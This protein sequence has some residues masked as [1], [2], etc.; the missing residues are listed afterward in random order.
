MAL[1]ASSLSQICKSIGQFV[2]TELNQDDTVVRVTIGNPGD[3]APADVETNRL[4]IFFFRFEPF[5]FDADL[6]PGETMF[7]RTHC[8]MTPFSISEQSVSTGENDLRLIGE[9]LR[10]F[11]ERPVLLINAGGGDFQVQVVM[12]SLALDQLNQLWSTQGEVT[13]RPSVLYEIS[14]APVIPK[15]QAVGAPIVGSLGLGVSGTMDR[16]TEPA[17][18][19]A[20][21]PD[22]PVTLV[23][24][25]REDWAPAICFVRGGACVQSLGFEA[26]GADIGAFAPRV[27]VAGEPG[28]AVSL[29]W[30]VWDASSGWSSLASTTPGTALGPRLDSDQVPAEA[31]TTAV[32]LPFT[33]HAGQAVLYAERSYVRA[34]DG[35]ALTVRSNP[36][37]VN[38]FGG[39]P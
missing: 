32:A 1:V 21:G 34:L 11:H 39:A 2:S 25:S 9:V 13:Y 10:V 28:A 14:L 23:D 22:V 29:R 27:W 26:G 18:S 31:D 12:Q 17:A 33:D 24:T 7:L 16:S 37:L 38:V 36:I 15:V 19:S 8:L 30:D 3:V 4:N 5:A 6:L 20:V 35:A